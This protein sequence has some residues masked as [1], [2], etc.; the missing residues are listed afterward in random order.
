[1]RMILTAAIAAI[2]F[3]GAAWADPAEGT[4]KTEVDDGAY[5]HVKMGMCG[6]TLCGTIARTFNASGEYKSENLGK[7]LVWDMSP[8]GGGAYK[9]GQIWQPSTG[10]TF[11]SKMALSGNTL[12]VSGCVGPI[13][14]KQT[15]SRVN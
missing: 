12:N 6:A 15:W 4:W 1:M 11:R 10:K 9:S 7:K 3:A 2:C 14:K 8:A 5:A 13:C